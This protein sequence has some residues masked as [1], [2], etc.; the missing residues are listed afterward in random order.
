MDNK[1]W[2]NEYYLVTNSLKKTKDREQTW[3]S[4]PFLSIKI[5]LKTLLLAY[6]TT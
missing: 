5:L 1:E 4:D 3:V 6:T 2:N